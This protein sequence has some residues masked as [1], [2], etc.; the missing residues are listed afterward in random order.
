MAAELSRKIFI[1]AAEEIIGSERIESL[2]IR[3]LAKKINCNTGNIYYYFNNL[4]E[5]TVYACMGYYASYLAE[6]SILHAEKGYTREAYEES[7]QIYI[8]HAFQYPEIFLKL[9]FGPYSR[10]LSSISG[11]YYKM[12]PEKREKLHSTIA[13]TLVVA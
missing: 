12:F 10:K 1:E 3:R 6:V 5:V 4:E 11:E 9:I 13:K 7:W 8:N 2:S